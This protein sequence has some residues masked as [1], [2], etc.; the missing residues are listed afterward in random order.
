MKPLLYV[1]C[2]FFGFESA[3]AAI[4]QKI[5]LNNQEIF[6]KSTREGNQE[7]IRLDIP[8]ENMDKNL[9]APEL[10]VRSWLVMGT[11]NSVR[12]QYQ[13]QKTET[14]TGRVYPVQEQECR[15]ASDKKRTFQFRSDLYPRKEM[16]QVEFLGSYRGQPVSRVDVFL[17]R[18]DEARG[19][20]EIVTQANINISADPFIFQNE[21]FNDYLIVVPSALAEGITKF[22]DEKRMQGYNVYVEVVGSP[23][24]TT[25]GL[26]TLIQTAY[27]QKG[28]DFVIL[29]G[30]ET[31]LPM[32]KVSTS[33]SSQ[34]PSD[35][36]YFTMD[37]ADD[38][39]PDVL[40]SRISASS[41]EQVA[42]QLQ[43]SIDYEK[44]FKMSSSGM[45]KFIGIAS[46]EGS[47]PSDDQYVRSIAERFKQVVQA[48]PI[49]LFQDDSVQSNPLFLNSEI[50]EG[51]FWLTYLGH[52]S[53]TSWP[54]MNQW[55]TTQNIKQLSNQTSVKPII[56][57]VACQNGKLRS[58]QLGTTFMEAQ[59][60]AFG[61]TA[62]YGGSVDISWHPP[63][64]M[65][66]GIAFEQLEKR[67]KHLGQ[68]LLAGQL[69]LAANWNNTSQVIDNFEWYHLQGD[70]GMKL[71]Y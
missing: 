44:T 57:D 46:N 31:S 65:A 37:G 22:V 21:D 48:E 34:T 40:G 53:G 12:V 35:L 49:H 68:A 55:Y 2:F 24:L 30:D 56:I 14:F 39:I 67:F 42:V 32:F 25:A 62:Y 52:G 63:A 3:Q 16:A 58:G 60:S 47:N 15:C 50:N 59:G 28:I 11:P 23:S 7:F 33:G 43:K 26:Q 17:G 66:R 6:Q 1:L 64:V 8:S 9:G 10:P 5:S 71:D 70:P 54:S 29:V 51:A 38:Y 45:K 13:V 41:A 20:F 4:Q 36:K 18:A 27:K 61:A 69:Y 19:S